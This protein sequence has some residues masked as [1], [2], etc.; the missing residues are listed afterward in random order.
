MA[1]RILAG[2]ELRRKGHTR[3][4]KGLVVALL[5]LC[6]VPAVFPQEAVP[7]KEYR[8]NKEYFLGCWKDLKAVALAPGKWDGPDIFNLAV[9][10]GVGTVLF[11]L[12]QD[13]FNYVQKNRTPASHD[14]FGLITDLGD[15]GVL[16]GLMGVIYAAGE[17]SD[18]VHLRKAALLGLQS[19]ATAGLLTAGLKFVVGR[20]R[21]HAWEGSQSF[22]VFSGSSRQTSFPSG[23][24]A[25]AF[26]VATSIADESDKLSVDILCYGLATMVAL[27]R[28]HQEKHWASDAF[29]GS[30]IGYFVAK[31]IASLHR[32][33]E[34]GKLR[35]SFEAS[36]Q[37]VALGLSLDF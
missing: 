13:I 2:K 16:A 3:A 23:H 34:A 12:D 36:P 11:T 35:F 8:L 29:V 28:V 7:E 5:I 37:R 14:F 20:A 1:L 24:S 33:R 17:F 15:G 22:R 27:S 9:S 19:L 10:F 32:S 31:K 30:A 6:S 21:P 18:R 25:A 26:A 4:G